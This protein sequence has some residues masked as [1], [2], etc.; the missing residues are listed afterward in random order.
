MITV[1]RNAILGSYSLE[2]MFLSLGAFA[3]NFRRKLLK[4]LTVFGAR[5]FPAGEFTVYKR[6]GPTTLWPDPT[7][8]LIL[9]NYL[10]AQGT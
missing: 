2:I 8:N 5:D 1:G 10:P 6:A 4:V 9:F 7:G 3:R